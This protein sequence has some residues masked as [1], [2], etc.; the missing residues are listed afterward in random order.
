MRWFRSVCS[1]L[2]K[3]IHIAALCGL[4]AAASPAALCSVSFSGDRPHQIET[5][6][7]L[8]ALTPVGQGSLRFLGL[9]IYEA[10]LFSVPNATGESKL[11]APNQVFNQP[12]V[13][14]IHYARSISLEQLAER[15]I[16]EMEGLGLVPKSSREQWLAH[17]F[18]SF[19]AVNS[20]DRITGVFRPNRGASFYLNGVLVHEVADPQFAEAFFRIWLDPKT[21]EP[22]LR[23]ALLGLN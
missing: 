20:G 17:L 23:R 16:K 6:Q 5:A 10:S 19:R 4:L 3:R 12:F 1:G 18:K 22:S 13:L 8:T 14:Q 15:S 7:G 9:R 2:H 21:S 11:T